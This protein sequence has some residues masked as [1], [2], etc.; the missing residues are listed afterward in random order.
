[1]L[2]FCSWIWVYTANLSELPWDTHPWWQT[3]GLPIL[4]ATTS[5]TGCYLL[6]FQK[7]CVTILRRGIGA[8]LGGL[9]GTSSTF[10]ISLSMILLSSAGSCMVKSLPLQI[11]PMISLVKSHYSSPFPIFFSD[12]ELL[13]GCFVICCGGE[14]ECTPWSITREK[15]RRCSRVRF[16]VAPMKSLT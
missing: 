11:H 13:P 16:F 5:R 15:C 3:L 2:G 1:M 10:F 14:I 6:V 8:S 4:H 9:T 12:T 7:W